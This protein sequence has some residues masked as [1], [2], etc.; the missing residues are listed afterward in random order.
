MPTPQLKTIL[1]LQ[2]FFLLW[3]CRNK[4]YPDAAIEAKAV[5][6]SAQLDSNDLATFRK[7]GL[8]LRGGWWRQEGDSLLYVCLYYS[9]DTP[10]IVV[11]EPEAFKADFAYDFIIDTSFYQRISFSKINDSTI[12]I[13]ASDNHGKEHLLSA[14][15]SLHRIFTS[16]DPFLHFKALAALTARLGIYGV[17]YRPDIGNFIEFYL[18]SQHVLTYMPE[19]LYLNPNS[20][21][22]W[23]SE[24]AKGKNIAKH[25]NLRKLDKPLDNG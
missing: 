8:D 24:F 15:I 5:T 10:T 17:S 18:S 20:Q 9:N 23:Q 12:R 6:I 16:R 22:I 13:S 1:L 19:H 2:I 7:W 14:G 25:W 4:E 11:A 21:K 3:G